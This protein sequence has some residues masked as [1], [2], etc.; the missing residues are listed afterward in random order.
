ML[1]SFELIPQIL[2]FHAG[3][4]PG[5]ASGGALRAELSGHAGGPPLLRHVEE[6][7]LIA[8][9]GRGTPDQPDHTVRLWRLQLAPTH[10]ADGARAPPPPRAAWGGEGAA[11]LPDV[12]VVCE[13][14]LTGHAGPL[15][16]ICFLPHARLL[17][18]CADDCTIRFWDP[19]ATP[20]LLTAPE[21]GRHVRVSAGRYAEMRPEWT[22]TNPAYVNCLLIQTEEPAVALAAAAE[23]AGPEALLVLTIRQP[24]R[25]AD[26]G[27]ADAGGSLGL[28][29][30]TRNVT[31]VDACRFDE[32]LSKDEYMK[33]EATAAR[34]WRDAMGKHSR[35]GGA[36]ASQARRDDEKRQRL[37]SP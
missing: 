32:P 18:S 25:V 15:N 29:G 4:D 16:D 13:R 28:W 21:G 6:Q 23:W 34:D 11:P 30:V 33:L 19:T 31:Q 7:D 5:A 24:W 12:V 2:A 35:T 10:G 3:G 1:A 8:S 14:V 20:H 26:A 9:G 36:Y 22:L 27:V 37:G 17:V